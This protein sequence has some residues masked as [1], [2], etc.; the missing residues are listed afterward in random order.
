MHQPLLDH[1]SRFYSLSESETKDI[2]KSFK[3]GS[4]KKKENLHVEG[5]VCRHN[6]FVCKGCLRMFFINDKGV[7]QTILFALENWW[8]SDLI[9]FQ[10]QKISGFYIQSVE[11]SEI[12]FIDYNDQKELLEKHPGLEKYFRIMYQYA[13]AA[14]QVRVKYM[15]D[16][17]KEEYYKMFNGLYPEFIQRI[18]QY[19]L[20]SFLGIT[21][22]YLSEIRKKNIS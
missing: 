14:S 4:F 3:S 2:I 11:I 9:S 15:Y 19:L 18:P 13:T 17:S 6:F 16:L 22:E 12:L 21:P 10:N 5:K 8:I 20:A 7:E 1:I